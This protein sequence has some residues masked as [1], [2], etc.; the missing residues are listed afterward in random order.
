M[1]HTAYLQSGGKRENFSRKRNHYVW[2]PVFTKFTNIVS[3]YIIIPQAIF[4][5][6]NK[7]PL[8]DYSALTLRCQGDAHIYITKC[9]EGVSLL[10]GSVGFS[11][12]LESSL[13]CPFTCLGF[14]PDGKN[15]PQSHLLSLASCGCSSPPWLLHSLPSCR[16]T[17]VL[18][19][20][21]YYSVPSVESIRLLPPTVAKSFRFLLNPTSKI[22]PTQFRL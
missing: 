14:L 11:P 4:F 2:T 5:N 16:T 9:H 7:H 10:D 21:P 19:T 17:T 18:L 22:Y 1:L 12:Y 15:Q 8:I 6:L 20:S 3:V 13:C